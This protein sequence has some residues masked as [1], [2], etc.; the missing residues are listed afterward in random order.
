MSEIGPRAGDILQGDPKL[1]TIGR[2]LAYSGGS[3]SLPGWPIANTHTNASEAARHALGDLLLQGTLYENY[4]NELFVRTYGSEWMTR[5][6][7]DVRFVRPVR[8]GQVL[9]ARAVLDAD[10]KK[11]EGQSFAVD[12]RTDSGELVLVGSAR[13]RPS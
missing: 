1:A 9:R 11:A 13:L 10:A 4:V 12:C 6:E 2:V 8:V 5:G 7:L 3:F